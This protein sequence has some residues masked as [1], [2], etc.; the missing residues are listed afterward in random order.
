MKGLTTLIKLHKRTLDELRRKMVSLENQKTQLLQAIASLR[1]ELAHEMKLAGVKPEMAQY[2]GGF[3]K[4]VQ[5][6]QDE[7]TAEIRKLD[8]QIVK[9]A[10]EIAVAYGEV[11]KFEIALENAKKRAEEEERR[12]ETILLDEVAGNQHRRQ[13]DEA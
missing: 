10:D 12:K 4:R 13:K 3:A 1:S 7:I 9:L 11:K 8:Q 2:F 5:K 6:R